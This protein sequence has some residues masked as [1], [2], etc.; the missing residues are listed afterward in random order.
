MDSR[1]RSRGPVPNKTPQN[2]R[3]LGKMVSEKAALCDPLVSS[4]AEKSIKR[5][6][7][8]NKRVNTTTT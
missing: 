3:V 4:A 1:V 5:A 7:E 8:E 2:F 6:T